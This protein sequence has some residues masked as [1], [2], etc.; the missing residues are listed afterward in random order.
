M[1]TGTTKTVKRGPH[2][3]L[4]VR[5][6]LGAGA[7]TLGV[8]AAL[9]GATAVAAADTGGHASSSS[10]SSSSSDAGPK[11]A[12][13]VAQTKRVNAPVAKVANARPAVAGKSAVASSQTNETTQTINTP[14]GPI[15]VAI[16]ATTPDLGQSGPVDLAVNASTPLGK[17]KLG[18]AGNEVFTAPT[19]Q[20]PTAKVQFSLTDGTLVVPKPV[21]FLVSSAGSAVL[22]AMSAYNSANAFFTAAQH[23][24][25]LGAAQAFLEGGPKMANAILF[26]QES[27]TLPI[28][29]GQGEPA[30]VS[31]PF[32]GFFAPLRPVTLTWPGYSYVDQTTGAEVTIDPVDIEFAGT[33]FG[34]VAGAL[35]QLIGLL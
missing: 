32:G 24:N 33:K 25:F 12:T 13:G 18:L 9:A 29:V 14:I 10:A 6:W 20:D 30:Q 2:R 27:L 5:T 22:G 8:G 34:G 35:G 26:G 31:I 15:T 1:A 19:Q 3:T 21:A 23:G 16:S 28:S 7:V 4:G 17:V 11:R